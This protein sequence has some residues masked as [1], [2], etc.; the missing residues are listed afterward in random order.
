MRSLSSG[1]ASYSV[2]RSEPALDDF[3]G[4]YIRPRVLAACLTVL[5][6]L[7]LK[8]HYS[9]AT[10]EQL[11]WILAPTATLVAWVTSANPV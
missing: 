4:T 7:L 8:H 5:I 2:D 6:M 9:V 11:D 3:M 1:I 10:A